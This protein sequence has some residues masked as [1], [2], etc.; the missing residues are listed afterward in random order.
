[1]F[2][3]LDVGTTNVKALLVTPQ[4]RIVA[5]GSA[6][7]PLLHP[8]PS[9]VEQDI[10]EIWQATRAAIRQVSCANDASA[11]RAIGVS[12][13][14]G[15]MQVLDGDRKPLGRVISWLD[16]R[17][18][19]HDEQITAEL[20]AKWFA[21]HTG[22][23]RSAISVGQILRLRQEAP[24]LLRRPN[25]I[26]YVGDVI[27]SRLCGRGAHDATSLSIAML[28]NPALRK[29]DPKLLRLLD[30][31]ED[32]L[33]DLLSARVMAGRL[34]DDVA[35]AVALPPGI[36]V[37]A[38]IHDQYAA[39]LGACV[40]HPGDVMFGAGTAWVLLATTARLA[41]PVIDS[42][43]VCTHVL[44]GLYGQMLSLANGGSA[45]RWALNLLGLSGRSGGELDELMASVPAGS[46]GVRFWPL[47]A[48]SGA[49][50]AP[51]TTGRLMGLRLSH[52]P[53]HILRAV[54]EGLALELARYLGFLKHGRI[55][56]TRLVMCGGA[57]ASRVTPQVIA[58]VTGLPVACTTESEMS[59]LGAAMLARGLVEPQ[60]LLAQISQAMT[61]A[62]RL[63]EPGAHAQTYAG[64]LA[65]YLAA[66]PYPL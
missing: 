54:V 56:A 62:V 4:G 18:R 36:P 15:A 6:P 53:A 24:E 41:S 3:G 29:A 35:A 49:G 8:D 50:L 34:S 9:A 38:A 66:L 39:S 5:R 17:G 14:G 55:P 31:G 64:L 23:G 43:F 37:S 59:A 33:P 19:P 27:V 58:D 25:R 1:M 7:V 63:V 32:Q 21:E 51:G 28:F 2:L 46:E 45:F 52:G 20:G 44:D 42:A 12:S 40:V 30:I 16:G 11:V 10:E 48:T 22:H 26:G 61:P 60:T 47:L 13:Q 57:A 65:E